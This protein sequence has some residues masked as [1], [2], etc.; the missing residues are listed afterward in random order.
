MEYL[1]SII[2]LILSIVALLITALIYQK[3]K[4]EV[5]IQSF[6]NDFAQFLAYAGQGNNKD[7]LITLTKLKLQIDRKSVV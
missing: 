6:F 4:N 7:A 3:Q 5:I 2:S 1:F